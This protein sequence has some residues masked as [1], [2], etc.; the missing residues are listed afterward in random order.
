MGQERRWHQLEGSELASEVSRIVDG[1]DSEYSYRDARCVRSME[2]YE[3][4]RLD[5]LSASA[6]LAEYDDRN[7]LRLNLIRSGCDTVLS[8]ISGKQKPKP[9]FVTSG[10]DYRQRRRA[11][12]LD[13]FVE[14]QLRLPQGNYSSAWELMEDAFMDALICG[15]GPIHVYADGDSVAIDRVPLNQ[16]RLD[17]AEAAS[18]SPRNWFRRGPID[19]DIAIELFCGVEAEGEEDDSELRKRSAILTA[20]PYYESRRDG[21]T[22]SQL[23]SRVSPPVQFDE[24]WLLP[25]QGS[26]KLG[27]HVI[28]IN[29][30]IMFD[31]PWERDCA[32]F[33]L[34]RWARE[35]A[36]FWGKSLVEEG[37]SIALEVNENSAKLQARFAL[38]GSKRT[39]YYE[40]SIDDEL[41]ESNEHEQL[42]KIKQG[43]NPPIEVAPQPVSSSEVDWMDSLVRKFY[44]F[45][46]ISQ[47]NATSRKE[48]GITAGVAIRTMNDMQSQ[49]FSVR[50]RQYETS[51]VT[52]G[53]LIV[54]AARDVAK[55]SGSY[56]LPWPGNKFHDSIDW[57]DI[58]LDEDMYEIQVAP[59]SALPNDPAGRMQLTQELFQAGVISP[60]TFKRLLDM[61]DLEDEMRGE[62]AER[63]RIE[64]EIDRMLDA[65]EGEEFEYHPPDGYILDPQAAMLMVGS[66]YHQAVQ[67]MAPEYN[68]SLLRA[69]MSN[70]DQLIMR[71]T[72]PQQGAAGG[73][74]ASPPT[75]APGG[76]LPPAVQPTPPGLVQ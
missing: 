58:D 54:A 71:M 60:Q 15:T 59:A 56:K 57:K 36:S 25:I 66:E 61:P 8:E 49:R 50:A 33:V 14:S 39:Y 24:A 16:L 51:Y 28:I 63:E 20:K 32:P 34:Q 45:T 17:P 74:E 29:N 70:L 43:H 53:K 12:K 31:E 55:N 68:L 23:D 40:G 30:E 42:I 1:L 3:G 47:M 6:Y 21:M 52:L 2:L 5:A 62:S 76:P 48:P 73:L 7:T 22:R 26:E 35:R 44:E 13:K 18:G 11:K 64:W 38:C 4:R 9:M 65:E 37:E 27:R 75:P 67:E 10:G 72:A 19:Q 69:Y 46:G 41:L